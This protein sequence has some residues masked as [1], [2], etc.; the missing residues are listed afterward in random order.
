MAWSEKEG[1]GEGER[2]RVTEQGEATEV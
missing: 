1:K 2:E